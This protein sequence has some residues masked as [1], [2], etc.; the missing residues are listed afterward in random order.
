[1]VGWLWW[2]TTEAFAQTDST[3][4]VFSTGSGF[5]FAQLCL[6]VIV[7]DARVQIWVLMGLTTTVC[8]VGDFESSCRWLGAILSLSSPYY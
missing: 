6:F 8:G 1:M 4:R 7:I 2:S 5:C 3:D